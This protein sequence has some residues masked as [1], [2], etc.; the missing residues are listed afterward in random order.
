MNRGYLTFLVY[1][2][3]LGGGVF[4]A[5]LAAPAAFSAA[6]DR[7]AAANLVGAMLDRWH[8]IALLA[9]L[10][11]LIAEW[12]TSRL[13]RTR[14]VVLLALALVLASSQVFVDLRIRS[15]RFDS[16]ISI[17]DLPAS[18]LTRREFGRLH[19]MSMGL[20]LAQLIAAA[21]AAAPMRRASSRK[22]G[23]QANPEAS[24]DQSTIRPDHPET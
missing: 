3:W 12:R 18:S 5:F 19:G 20:M 11:L 17:S 24:P 8:Y 15:M 16:I 21:G 22:T 7:V 6:S 4:L 2:L 9:P 23:S 10:V 13:A 1:A 14:I